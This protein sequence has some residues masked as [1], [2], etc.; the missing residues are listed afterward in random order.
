M[1]QRAKNVVADKETRRLLMWS[2]AQAEIDFHLVHMK[3]IE[4]TLRT[5]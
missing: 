4:G 2:A 1:F 5:K 3:E